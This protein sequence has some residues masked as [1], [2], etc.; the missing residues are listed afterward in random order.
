MLVPVPRDVC[1]WEQ[2]FVQV[3]VHCLDHATDAT[4]AAGKTPQAM[5][6]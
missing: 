3:V 4:R 2:I 6:F 1:G 5:T